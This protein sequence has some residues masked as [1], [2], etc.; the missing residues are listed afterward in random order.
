MAKR[1]IDLQRD[2]AFSVKIGDADDGGGD[3]GEFYRIGEERLL[4]VHA[5]AVY[6]LILP[7]QIDPDR[8]NPN[9][10]PVQQKVLSAG[11]EDAVV[12]RVLFTAKALF[13]S[14]VLK[15]FD[16]NRAAA[17][18]FELVK[19]INAMREAGDELKEIEEKAEG[20][21]ASRRV[22]NGSL[23]LPSVPDLEARCKTFTQRAKDALGHIN[24]MAKLFFGSKVATK[25]WSAALVQLLIPHDPPPDANF[26]KHMQ[27]IAR[28]IFQVAE[29][30]NAV[31]H[32]KSDYRLKV[33][34]Y[35]LGG[36]GQ[37]L[38]PT[39]ELIHPKGTPPPS[40]AV[41]VLYAASAS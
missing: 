11:Y 20:K 5:R 41:E 10:P 15:D 34:D 16:E 32:P 26:V 1:P 7:D 25:N 19:D 17:L 12:S 37:I 30:R 21:L 38:P 13:R 23:S 2:S 36:D 39:V 4:T 22:K 3:L 31:V 6:E 28:F 40:T 18:A 33:S 27:A 9:I 24:D 35:R 8:T 14:S 29:I